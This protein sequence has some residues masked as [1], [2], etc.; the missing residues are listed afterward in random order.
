MKGRKEDKFNLCEEIIN[1][2]LEYIKKRN[3]HANVTVL[4]ASSPYVDFSRLVFAP[5]VLVAATGSSWAMWSAVL[6][7]NNTVVAHIPSFGT[8]MPLY[9]VEGVQIFFLRVLQSLF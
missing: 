7:N 4:E 1:T 2:S 6:A 8:I 3:P 5:N 9:Y